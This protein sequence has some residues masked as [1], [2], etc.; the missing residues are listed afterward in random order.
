MFVSDRDSGGR[1]ISLGTT[2]VCKEDRL[3]NVAVA[4]YWEGQMFPALHSYNIDTD[5]SAEVSQEY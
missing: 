4:T 3:Y 2:F 1:D 5:E